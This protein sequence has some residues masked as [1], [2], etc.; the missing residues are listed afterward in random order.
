MRPP[1]NHSDS[2]PGSTGHPREDQAIVEPSSNPTATVPVTM[3]TSTASIPAPTMVRKSSAFPAF[4]SRPRVGTQSVK[5][6][7]T[8]LKMGHSRGSTPAGRSIQSN[9]PKTRI[10]QPTTT[11]GLGTNNSNRQSSSHSGTLASSSI[12]RQTIPRTISD[13]PDNTHEVAS[14]KD[15][16]S[17]AYPKSQNQVTAEMN[18]T[19]R[20]IVTTQRYAPPNSTN[21]YS[22]R[23]NS[24]TPLPPPPPVL[25]PVQQSRLPGL[26]SLVR[27]ANNPARSGSSFAPPAVSQQL[28][29][30]SLPLRQC[31]VSPHS[32][33]RR[34]NDYASGSPP[35]PPAP[36][37]R[38]T[39]IR[40][41][42]IPPV[43]VARSGFANPLPSIQRALIPP[44]NERPRSETT[45]QGLVQNV[46][47]HPSLPLIFKA[48]YETSLGTNLHVSDRR[49]NDAIKRAMMEM[50]RIEAISRR[51]GVASVA[52]SFAAIDLFFSVLLCAF[53]ALQSE[54][55]PP[56]P[57]PLH[58]IINV[59]AK[60]SDN[61][62][63][64]VG[65]PVESTST[66]SPPQQ[67]HQQCKTAGASNN[68]APTVRPK[69]S[70]EARQIL[71]NWFQDNFANPYPTD[72][73][74]KELAHRC[75]LQLNQVC[76]QLPSGLNCY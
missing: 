54:D 67:N 44:S 42:G 66:P 58:T 30:R 56:I 13:N 20:V 28:P 22:Y 3:Q 34:A 24:R 1:L 61:N 16:Y 12:A 71:E 40:T 32:S 52:K 69:L 41:V 29:S 26:S 72:A 46:L 37:Q 43:S 14:N 55:Q 10:E 6:S 70:D 75:G 7:S 35:P 68:M 5:S 73:V 25:V 18:S 50:E 8:T 57:S 11:S 49:A 21:T 62:A 53:K 2:I 60:L 23:R 51:E 45:F 27:D 9:P 33:A 65:S 47:H 38:T 17:Q 64:G 63:N 36:Q 76:R 31:Y 19:P 4:G 48:T 39:S 59:C 74:K 15:T